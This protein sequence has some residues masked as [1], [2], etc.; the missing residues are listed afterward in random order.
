MARKKTGVLVG[1]SGLIGGTIVNY[2]KTKHAETVDI[3]APSSKKLSIREEADIRDYLSSVKPDFIINA[4]MATLSSDGQLAFEVNYLGTLN[5]ARAANALNIPYIHISSAATLPAGIDLKE[6]D[7]LPL[8]PRMSNYA[9]SKLMAEETLRLMSRD[10]GLDCSCVRLAVVYGAHDHKIQGFH[11]LLFS[12]ADQSMPVLFTR[13]NTLHSYSNARKLPYFIEHILNNR[14]EFRGKTIHFVDKNPVDLANLIL[15]IKS[16]LQLSTPKE[17]YVPY[18]MANSGKKALII[19]LRFLRKFGLKA[20]LPPELMFLNSFYKSQVLS[21][22]RLEASSFIDPMPE[23]TIYTR[24]PELIIYYLTRWS[25]QNLI[26]TYDECMDLEKPEIDAF[27]HNPREL[28]DSVH[29]KGIGPF[30]EMME[31]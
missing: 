9:K 30:S 2:Y 31:E 24:L 19:L 5:L 8:V 15:T 1:G 29:S 26:T 11:R 12:I 20:D 13:K 14:D 3:R 23:E 21:S 4:A 6:E 27:L 28:L 7:Y 18:L 22:A 10:Q 16:Y 17:I 25:H